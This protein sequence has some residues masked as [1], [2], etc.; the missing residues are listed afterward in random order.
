M[1]KSVSSDQNNSGSGAFN[2]QTIVCPGSN[3]C[4]ANENL[5]KLKSIKKLVKMKKCQ[6]FEKFGESQGLND[7]KID[8]NNENNTSGKENENKSEAMQN[9]NNGQ[10]KKTKNEH[11]PDTLSSQNLPKIPINEKSNTQPQLKLGYKKMQIDKIKKE[12]YEKIVNS[13]NGEKY[14][15]TIRQINEE[16][17]PPASEKSKKFNTSKI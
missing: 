2:S 10:N 6:D 1:M 8:H 4:N 14:L 16:N 3:G 5:G 15:K 17:T 13:E 12:N 11:V 7:L 9:F